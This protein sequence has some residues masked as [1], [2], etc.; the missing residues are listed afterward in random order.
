MINMSGIERSERSGFFLE[1]NLGEGEE[2]ER[3]N[4]ISG[5]GDYGLTESS[6]NRMCTDSQSLS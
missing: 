1:V 2:D 4:T 3:S 6:A 5:W